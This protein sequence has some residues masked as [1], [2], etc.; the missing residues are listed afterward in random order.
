VIDVKKACTLLV[1]VILLHARSTEDVATAASANTSGRTPTIQSRCDIGKLKS[2]EAKA[3]RYED[4][5]ERSAVRALFAYQEAANEGRFCADL[6]QPPIARWRLRAFALGAFASADRVRQNAQIAVFQNSLLSLRFAML[7]LARQ[8]TSDL[9]APTAV[10]TTVAE[11]FIDE[12][13]GAVPVYVRDER[14]KSCVSI[15]NSSSPIPPHYSDETEGQRNT[16]QETRQSSAPSPRQQAARVAT[17]CDEPNRPY[18][19]LSK[20]IAVT[21]PGAFVGQHISFS[22]AFDSS[23]GVASSALLSSS[24]DSLLDKFVGE[25]AQ[26][27]QITPPLKDCVPIGTSITF[28]PALI[29]APVSISEIRHWVTYPPGSESVLNVLVQIVGNANVDLA[30][31]NIGILARDQSETVLTLTGATATL[32]SEAHDDSTQQLELAP[33]SSEKGHP[34]DIQLRHGDSLQRVVTFVMPRG[35]GVDQGLFQWL[36]YYG[37][38]K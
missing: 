18:R 20:H 5:L 31:Q 1:V 19:W 11:Y 7:L 8:I 37:S 17:P 29:A 32:A 21:V 34:Y 22:V 33:S 10:R 16:P 35:I 15:V 24:G 27:L 38:A 28:E 3:K 25:M 6:R 9:N 14:R 4:N 12:C 30:P 2:L 26:Q 13:I 36:G 23:G